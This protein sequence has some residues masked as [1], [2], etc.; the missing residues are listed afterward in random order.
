MNVTRLML[1]KGCLMASIAHAIMTNIYPEFSYEHSWDG[2]NYS[3]QNT[4]GMR[5]TIT[6]ETD[7]CIGAIRDDSSDY[8]ISEKDIDKHIADFPL[9]IVRKAY[10]ET[11]RYLLLDKNGYA[12]PCITSIFYAD[13]TGIHFNKEN[14]DNLKSDF[15][16]L[17]DVIVSEEFAIDLWGDY[18]E[19]DSKAIELLR[20]LYE[21]KVKDFSS[22]IVLSEEQIQM[23]PGDYINDECVESLEELNIFLH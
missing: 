22:K 8:I 20:S 5:G 23:I 12:T 17:E 9:E 21:I 16:L 2:S 14:T 18:Y 19:M 15:E 4:S 7:Y 1:F 13:D 10:D 3:I 11:L 6:F